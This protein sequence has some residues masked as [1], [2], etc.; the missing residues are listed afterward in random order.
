MKE[1]DTAGHEAV[2]KFDTGQ[3]VMLRWVAKA[4]TAQ[5]GGRRNLAR[6]GG[7]LSGVVDSLLLS[8]F[9][10]FSQ[11]TQLDGSLRG[12]SKSFLCLPPSL[13]LQFRSKVSPA[14]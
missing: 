7:K 3:T 13:I 8:N 6:P 4:I 5:E 2:W 9:I 14:G 10:L 1:F 11:T 12:D